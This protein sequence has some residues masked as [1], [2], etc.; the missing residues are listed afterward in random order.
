MIEALRTPDQRFED[1]PGWSFEPSYLTLP[2]SGL[3]MHYVDEG[4]SA[5]AETFLCLHGQPTW[6]YLYRKM[7]PI[8]AAAGKRV[9]VPDF[10]GFGRSD[11][12]IA[13]EV[14]TFDFHRASL[15]ELIAALELDNL[16]LVVQDWGGLIGL[17]VPMEIPERVSRL[18]LMNTALGT[19]DV[20]LPPAFLA[21]REFSDRHPDMRI[22]ELMARACP[23]LTPPEC[24]AYEAP[25]PDAS[26]KGGVRRFPHLVPEN[27]GDPGAETARRARD[28]LR[29]EWSGQSFMAIGMQ[30]EIL[31]PPAMRALRKVVRGC[32]GPFEIEEAG[33]FVQEWGEEVARRS[34]AAFAS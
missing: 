34:L 22:A 26:Y 24:A 9:V 4:H 25:F 17:T 29:R 27:P 20:P 3:R 32:P 13:D 12:P 33:H 7:I 31:G 1:L 30:D 10:L 8:Y 28:W 21:W 14:F 5:A 16:T 6:G 18:V 15:L 11:K 23:R 19:G 2:G